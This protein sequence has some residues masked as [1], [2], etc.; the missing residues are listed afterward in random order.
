MASEEEIVARMNERRAKN[1][2]EAAELRRA[3]D[4]K[5]DEASRLVTSELDRV[6]QEPKHESGVRPDQS[7]SS[8]ATV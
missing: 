5:A 3:A 6:K 2:A 8:S 1:R 7:G 4:A